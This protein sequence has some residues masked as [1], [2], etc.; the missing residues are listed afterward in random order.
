M[1]LRGFRLVLPFLL[2]TLVLN[3]AAAEDVCPVT[4]APSPPFVP[5]VPY[6]ANPYDE[7]F[8]YGTNGLWTSLPV[9]G[10][11]RLP[12]REDGFYFNKLF[13]W[14]EGWDWRK[15]PY[16]PGPDI[17]LVLRRLNGNTS[18][19]TSRGGT[20]AFFDD[21]WAMLTGVNFPTEGCWE[22]TSFHDGHKLTFVLS[23]HGPD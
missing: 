22:I 16:P 8:W 15:E 6:R 19:I 10:V 14:Q 23:I 21:S 18:P 1:R 2:A 4:T 3:Q 17:K 20:N 5:P 13:L 9:E 12:R 7:H 11:W